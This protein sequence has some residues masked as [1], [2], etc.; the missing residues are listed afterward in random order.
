M[1][2]SE[3]LPSFTFNEVVW[4]AGNWPGGQIDD[5]MELGI[6]YKPGLH[7]LLFG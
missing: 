3:L 5:T 1:R 2:Y 4:V 6:H 7:P